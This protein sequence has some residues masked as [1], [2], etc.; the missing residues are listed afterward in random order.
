MSKSDIF[1]YLNG[2]GCCN[3]CSLRY[4]NGRFNNYLNVEKSLLVHGIDFETPPNKSEGEPS[5]K[6]L[7]QNEDMCVA[8]LGL[9]SSSCLD[10]VL[11]QV[12]QSRD[13]KLYENETV[14]TSVSLP[15]IV[16]LRRLSIWV[17][18]NEKFPKYFSSTDP[19]DV[20]I[21]DVVKLI[22]NP[23]ICEKLNKTLELNQSGIMINL[24]FEY[25]EESE[26]L[27]P[28]W[29]VK[30]E[31]IAERCATPRKFNREMMTRAAFEKHFNPSKMNVHTYAKHVPV[32]PTF[33]KKQLKLDKITINGPTVFVAGRYRKLSRSL[34]QTPWILKGKRMMEESVSEIIVENVAEFFGVCPENVIFSSSGREDVDVRCLGKGRPFVLEIPD[35]RKSVLPQSAAGVMEA[36]VEKTHKVSIRN[37]QTVKREELTHIKQGEENKKKAYRALCVTN[38]PVTV[39]L[40]KKLNISQEFTTDQIT[41]VRVL[42]RRPLRIRQRKIYQIKG[43]ISKGDYIIQVMLFVVKLFSHSCGVDDHRMIILDIITEAGTYIKELVHGEFGRT[44]PSICSIIGQWIDIVA[45]DVMKIDLEWPPEVNN[46]TH[47]SS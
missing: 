23:K 24:F 44:S 26:E 4:L 39:E 27:K 32:P 7:K 17:A 21:K 9:F 1:N 28:L 20:S 15:I 22:L 25:P 45:L 16:S 47:C 12:F 2:I 35:A 33:P 38:K 29:E 8:C 3:T 40:L 10:N 30:P 11:E 42:H 19:P 5:A 46:F 13:I 14:L 18:L 43:A 34:S 36:V 6:R 31:L 41:P 37:L